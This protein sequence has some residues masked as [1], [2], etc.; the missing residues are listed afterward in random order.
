MAKVN[1]EFDPFDARDYDQAL[2]TLAA[3][4]AGV[5]KATTKVLTPAEPIAA[6]GETL[7]VMKRKARA[8]AG[9]PRGPNKRTTETAAPALT[10]VATTEQPAVEAVAAEQA[11]IPAAS[12]APSLEDAR[13]ALKRV[14]DDQNRGAAAGMANLKAFG[15]TRVGDLPEDRRAAFIAKCDAV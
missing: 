4:K 6:V 5:D 7:R 14:V 3:I 9:K 10:P 1:I 12:T 11:P 15:V 13:A 2:V 8:D